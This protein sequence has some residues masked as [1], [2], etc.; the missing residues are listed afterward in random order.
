MKSN[1]KVAYTHSGAFHADDVCS[2]WL[3]KKL[4]PDI[5]IRRVPKIP[6]EMSK[7]ELAFDIGFGH[8]DHHQADRAMRNNEIP[9]AAFGLLWME[10]GLELLGGDTEAFNIFDRTYVLPVDAYDNGVVCGGNGPALQFS[11]AVATFNANWDDD[12]ASQDANFAQAVEWASAFLDK[13]LASALSTSRAKHLVEQAIANSDG[14]VLILPRF[15]PWQMWLSVSEQSKAKSMMFAVF[16]SNRGGFVAQGIPKIPGQRGNR[17]D[18]P[19]EWRG[20][21]P[22]ELKAL[23]GLNLTFCHMAGFILGSETEADAIAAAKLAI[24]NQQ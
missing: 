1:Y 19:V 21:S 6:T 10:F 4:W 12:A 20:K 11:V 9:F 16:P 24:A 17:L 8:F 15:V 7:D 14:E 2:T 23:T 18:F 13:A 5:E 3:V 22:D